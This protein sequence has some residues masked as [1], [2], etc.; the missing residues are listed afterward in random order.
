MEI[1]NL[2][3]QLTSLFFLVPTEKYLCKLDSVFPAMQRLGMLAWIELRETVLRRCYTTGPIS[4]SITSLNLQ[5]HLVTWRLE[6]EPG[7]LD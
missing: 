2:L 3:S 1:S 5:D 6:K 4:A 7:D